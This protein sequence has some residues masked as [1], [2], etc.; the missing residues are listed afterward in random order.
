[1][2]LRRIAELLHLESTCLARIC[3]K[4]SQPASICQNCYATAAGQWLIAESRCQIKHLVQRIGANNTGLAEQGF[5]RDITRRQ[6]CRMRSG[7]AASS[8]RSAGFHSD[9]RVAAAYP[10][11]DPGETSRVAEVLKIKKDNFGLFFFFPV[12][13]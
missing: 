4:N 9:D 2:I 11:G 5:H 13:Q 1:A 6:C 3:A 7:G 10:S 12:L 8:V